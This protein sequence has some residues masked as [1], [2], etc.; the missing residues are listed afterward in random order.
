MIILL[1]P[2]G[3]ILAIA[4]RAAGIF[5]G[6]AGP[7]A[8]FPTGPAAA[9]A[10]GIDAEDAFENFGNGLPVRDAH[11]SRAALRTGQ[12]HSGNLEYSGSVTVTLRFFSTPAVHY[13]NRAI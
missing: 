2:G 12:L 9:A 4:A 8:G 10:Q 11:V 3:E 5:P 13:N 1:A 7:D 6:S